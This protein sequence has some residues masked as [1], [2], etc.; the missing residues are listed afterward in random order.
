[1][2]KWR[3]KHVWMPMGK[4]V[5]VMGHEAQGYVCIHC[6][7]EAYLVRKFKLKVPTIPWR[8]K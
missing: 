1:M 4:T 3:C 8:N 5:M 2:G 7:T 6:P